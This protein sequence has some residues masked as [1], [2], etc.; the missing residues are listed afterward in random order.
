MNI[1]HWL[2]LTTSSVVVIAIACGGGSDT[3]DDPATPT[4][5]SQVTV[6]PTS[7]VPPSSTAIVSPT[8]T[9]QRDDSLVDLENL[10]VPTCRTDPF[11][12]TSVGFGTVP[13]HPDSATALSPDPLDTQAEIIMALAPVLRWVGHFTAIADT[14]WDFA[15]TE[16]EYAAAI[17]DEGRRLWL[18]CN[19]FTAAAPAFN[20]GESFLVSVIVSLQNRRQW[21]ADRLEVLRTNPGS[22][23]NDDENR[24]TT[25]SAL[26]DLTVRL[27]EIA[28][29]AGVE[30]RL[31][32]VPF[33]VPNPLLGVSLEVPGGWM[34][35]RNRVDIVVVAPPELQ[36]DGLAGL[37]VPGW[38]FGTALRVRRL[39]H[40]A[41]WTLNDSMNIMD[42]LLV[43]FG[44]RSTDERRR[45]GDGEAVIRVYESP[46]DG[47]VTIAAATVRDLHTY[48]FEL[49]CPADEQAACEVLMQDYLDGVRFITE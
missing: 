30:D 41:P 48:L 35:I 10:V 8:G 46:D 34:L 44:E 16:Q 1:F 7:T 20:T 9:P 11:A 3:P 42:S 25:S 37:G 28:I 23:R 24:A 40:E 45:L 33:S 32:S 4:A 5:I 38:N 31:A 21:L 29:A 49:G 27:G 19:A 26:Q 13:R 15:R 2:L 47:W 36:G 6:D 12:G 14:A 43:R 22:I 39:R 17:S 18:S